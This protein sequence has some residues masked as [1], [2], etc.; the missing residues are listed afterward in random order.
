MAQK[1][2]SGQVWNQKVGKCVSSKTIKGSQLKEAAIDKSGKFK[3]VMEVPASEV[4]PGSGKR[5]YTGEA[6]GPSMSLSRKVSQS[7]ARQKMAT[8]PSDSIRAADVDVYLGKK[9]PKRSLFGRRK[10]KRNK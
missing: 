10:K 7:R 8:T 3:S 6:G 4:G 1:C 5:Y 2:G 9:K